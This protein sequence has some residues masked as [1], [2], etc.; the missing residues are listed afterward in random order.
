MSTVY[1]YSARAHGI[2]THSRACTCR[3]WKRAVHTDNTLTS[4]PSVWNS[5]RTVLPYREAWRVT[6]TVR[7]VLHSLCHTLLPLTA[8]LRVRALVFLPLLLLCLVPTTRPRNLD[9]QQTTK[10]IPIFFL[11]FSRRHSLDCH[12]R[13]K[14][15]H[16][17]EHG[18]CSFRLGNYLYF[19]KL[20]QKCHVLCFC[21]AQDEASVFC[22]FS[23]LDSNMRLNQ[24]I[25]RF[26]IFLLFYD[27]LEK[28]SGSVKVCWYFECMR[29]IMSG[30]TPKTWCAI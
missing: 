27:T 21:N 7:T 19:S 8:D 5:D 12:F 3:A 1:I 17:W 29:T 14:A 16:I 22:F 4:Y 11:S 30:K 20:H 13:I 18:G 26:W 24:C 28:V 25:W 9:L 23:A 6:I 15:R 2:C 10:T